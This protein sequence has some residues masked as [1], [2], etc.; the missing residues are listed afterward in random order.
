MR[1]AAASTRFPGGQ[2]PKRGQ[3]YRA[4][5]PLSNWRSLAK[6]NGMIV[7]ILP[8]EQRGQ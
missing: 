3:F 6:P 2:L 4:L 1:V 8:T 5:L 7:P